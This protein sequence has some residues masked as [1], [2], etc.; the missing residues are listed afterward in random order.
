MQVVILT[1]VCNDQVNW[2][3]E[4][5]LTNGSLYYYEIYIDTKSKIMI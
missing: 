3:S 5:I 4:S 2:V 1:M